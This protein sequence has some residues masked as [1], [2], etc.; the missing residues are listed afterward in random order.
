MALVVNTGFL[1]SLDYSLAD[2]S[3]RIR[4]LD[5]NSIKGFD[6]V[7]SRALAT[8]DDCTSMAHTLA[9]RRLTA[10][11]EGGYRFIR[12]ILFDPGSGIFFRIA[13]DLANDQNSFCIRIVLEELQC[14]DEV[15][16]LDRV[17][18]DTNSCGLADTSSR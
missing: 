17:A 5:A 11:N 1:Q 7:C 15:C 18:T 3:D 8:R 12:H 2:M 16:T 10:G 14:I 9:R 13:T 6:L 4:Y